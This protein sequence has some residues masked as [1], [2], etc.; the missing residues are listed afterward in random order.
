MAIRGQTGRAESTLPSGTQKHSL[1]TGLKAASGLLIE[2][3]QN[4]FSDHRQ[5]KLGINEK[6]VSGKFPSI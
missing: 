3:T 1:Y 5:I 2:V 6:N 4:V